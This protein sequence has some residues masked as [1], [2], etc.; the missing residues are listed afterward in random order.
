MEIVFVHLNSKLPQYL[1]WNL[2]SHIKNFPDHKVTLIHSTNIKIPFIAGLNKV[3][4][5]EDSRWQELDVLYSHPKDFRSNFWLTS[6]ARLFALENY[7][8]IALNEMVHVESDV[9]LARDFP[10]TKL[11][12]L[13]EGLAFPLISDFRGVASVVYLR[14]DK[15]ARTLTSKLISEATKNSQTTEMLSLMEIYQSNPAEIFVLPIGNDEPSF[16]RNVEASRQQTLIDSFHFFG[17]IFDGV[18]IGQ[19]FLGT[20]P[21]NRRGRKLI[22]HDLVDGYVNVKKLKLAFDDNREFL[23]VLEKDGQKALPLYAVHVPSKEVKIFKSKTQKKTLKKLSKESTGTP[24]EVICMKSI[25]FGVLESLRRRLN[26][27]EKTEK[28]VK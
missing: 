16:Y 26:S 11:S 22:N 9:I 5:R 25:F 17:G 2:V 15:S 20:D 21:R 28:I 8:K 12:Q 14:D 7:M 6:S 23:N 13:R 24:K 4:V 18:E 1:Y 19:F 10:F 27:L 3:T